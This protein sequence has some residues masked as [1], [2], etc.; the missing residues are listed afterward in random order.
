MSI[1]ETTNEEVSAAELEQEINEGVEVALEGWEPAEGDQLTWAN[2]GF[3]RLTAGV[4]DQAAKIERG[5]FKRFGEAIVSVPPVQAAAATVESTWTMVDAA[6]YTIPA[7][8]QVTISA[9]GDS[10]VG[11]ITVENVVVAPEVT[12]AT[13]LL[14]AIEAGE[15]GND[16]SADPELSDS[17]A[18]VES[19]S[20]EGTTSGGVG[21]ESEDDYLNRLV[22]EM[23]TRS[24]SLILPRDFEIDARAVPG[25]ARAKCIR[26]YDAETE[27]EGVA[28]TQTIFPIDSDGQAL[29][30][31]AKEE[32][33]E[34]QVAKLLTDVNHHVADPIYNPIHV[35]SGIVP[36]TGFDPATVTAAVDSRQGEYFDPAN[37]GLPTQG[38][39][40]SGWEDRVIVFYNDVIAELDRVGGV[41]RVATLLLGIGAGK[42]FTVAAA[43]D[44][45]SS[46]AHGFSNG[47]SVVLLTGL[48]PGAPLAVE[49]V[50]YVRDVEA[51]AFKLAATVGGAA[52]NITSD[53]SG[54]AVKVGT[55]DVALTG[56][57]PLTELGESGVTLA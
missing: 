46:V 15:G 44:K 33:L 5:A 56:V 38:D 51:N 1:F 21:E 11:F 24:S 3:S 37:W 31:P 4:Y 52:I 41:D 20:L 10:A 13:V 28:L 34:R 17:L 18:F 30:A 23:Q 35:F 27:E 7:G 16:L 25:V 50:Y 6:G 39:S 53:G 9:S 57:A 55:A 29:G 12:A 42:A 43:T 22:E 36:Q 49:T 14:Q 45:L 8:T 48:V 40:G 2:K 54:S 32:L 47:D 26:N 19:I